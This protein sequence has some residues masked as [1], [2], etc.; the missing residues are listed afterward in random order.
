MFSNDLESFASFLTLIPQKFHS[1]I[2]DETLLME[3]VLDIGR[4]VVIRYFDHFDVLDYKT[5]E[6]DINYVVDR[7]GDFGDDD[8]AGVDLQL[9]RISCIR[10]R[11]GDI[12]GLTCRLGRYIPSAANPIR[13]IVESGK[14]ILF[15]GKPGVGKSTILR[16]ISSILSTEQRKNVIIIDTSNELCGDGN[17][18]HPSIGYARRMQVRNVSDQHIVMQRAVENHTPEVIIIDEIGNSTEARA[19]R[20]IAERGVQLIGTA[21]GNT[22]EDLLRNPELT[23]LVGGVQAVI[24][25]DAEA[26]K[27]GTQKSILERKYPPTFDVLVELLDRQTIVVHEDICAAVDAHLKQE[28]I[29]KEIRHITEDGKVEIVNDLVEESTK[30]VDHIRQKN[31]G[32]PKI[33]VYGLGQSGKDKVEQAIKR[34]GG[35]IQLARFEDSATHVVIRKRLMDRPDQTVDR[36]MQ[37]DIVPIVVRT[38]NYDQIVAAIIRTFNIS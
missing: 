4:N 15:L 9:H 3:V 28:S 5:T 37:N 23:D 26:K 18:P 21:H 19:A 25:G 11:R 17:I 35:R 27:R 12:I 8:R 20:T 38:N 30:K 29:S 13:D 31:V 32:I 16:A 2:T 7:V 36:F 24:L 33:Y 6:E 22:I 10:N 1:F 34:F 14:S